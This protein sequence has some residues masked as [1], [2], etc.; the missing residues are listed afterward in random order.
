[1]KRK[2]S[3]LKWMLFSLPV[4]VVLLAFAFKLM[5]L[6][7]T[8]QVAIVNYN[9]GAYTA[10]RDASSTLLEGDLLGGNFIEPWI[11]WFNRGD[12]KAGDGDY[13]P[14]IDDFER[15][16][17]L[18]PEDKECLVRV[19]LSLSWELLGDIYEA[20]GYH[21]GAVQLYEAGEAVITDAG[22][23]CDPPDPAAEE[24]DAAGERLEDKKAAA[25]EQSDQEA[26]AEPDPSEQEQKLDELGDKDGESGQQKADDEARDRGEDEGGSTYTDKPW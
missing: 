20:E 24:L 22:D 8:T 17:D 16:L 26:A 9:S 21:D 18:A 4:A 15:A 14:A 10:S 6:S 1:M 3:R 19:N 13:T 2:H 25:Q 23:K 5:G 11:P 12:A 7:V